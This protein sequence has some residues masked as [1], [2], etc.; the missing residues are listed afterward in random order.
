MSKELRAMNRAL[1]RSF[2]LLARVLIAQDEQVRRALATG[3]CLP[4]FTADV[5]KQL[6][7]VWRRDKRRRRYGS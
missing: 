2:G 1:S 6:V 7:A 4:D 5:W 3:S